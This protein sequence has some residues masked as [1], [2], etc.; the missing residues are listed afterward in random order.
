MCPKLNFH[1]RKCWVALTE[2][3]CSPIFY[4]KIKCKLERVQ[5]GYIK[6][7]SAVS[8]Y[9]LHFPDYEMVIKLV[10]LFQKL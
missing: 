8:G 3:V 1:D 9:S 4:N 2:D 7:H 5:E 10:H 6:K